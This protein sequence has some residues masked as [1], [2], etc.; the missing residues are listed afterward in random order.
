LTNEIDKTIVGAV[1]VRDLIRVIQRNG[2]FLGVDRCGFAA[3]C[4]AGL[5][6]P[7]SVLK[8]GLCPP[9]GT[10]NIYWGQSPTKGTAL[11]GN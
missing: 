2:W 7:L 4:E 1:K 3:G 10:L 11:L 5:A 9:F 8:K 6:P